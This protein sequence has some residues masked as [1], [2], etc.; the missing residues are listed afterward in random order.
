MNHFQE[1]INRL[2]HGWCHYSLYE[3]RNNVQSFDRFCALGALG[4]SM[5]GL[6]ENNP[7]AIKEWD[8]K[9]YRT[10]ENA[11]EARFLAEEI[12]KEYS[13]RYETTALESYHKHHHPDTTTW[14]IY[15][16]NDT[17]AEGVDDVIEMFKRASNEWEIS[18]FEVPDAIEEPVGV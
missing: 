11:E 6:P 10:L 8:D 16:F 4:A 1:A 15:R 7:D 18:R 2:E 12:L 17:I 5:L 3:P 13:D 9:V 14:I